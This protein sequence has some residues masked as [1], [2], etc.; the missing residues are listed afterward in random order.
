MK[1]M[2]CNNTGMT[3]LELM[4]A[5]GIVATAMSVLFGGLMSISIIGRLNES[6]TVAAIALAGVMEEINTLPLDQI[7]KYIPPEVSFP[8]QDYNLSVECLV[9]SDDESDESGLK[10]LALPLGADSSVKLQGPLEVRATLTWRENG[11]QIFQV[12]ASTVRGG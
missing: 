6:R 11:G 10:A 3:L 9:P 8:C 5:S 7:A 2:R 4:F 12:K 1:R